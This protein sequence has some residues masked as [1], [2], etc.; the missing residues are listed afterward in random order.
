MVG[1]QAVQGDFAQPSEA[2]S[3]QAARLLLAF[4]NSLDPP[5]AS[6]REISTPGIAAE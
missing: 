4:E 3:I 5:A 2:V 1:Q 6:G